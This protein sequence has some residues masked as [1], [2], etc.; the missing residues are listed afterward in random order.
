VSLQLLAAM[1]REKL[2][3][4]GG[5]ALRDVL[6]LAQKTL[7][8]ARRAVW[9]MRPPALEG[10]D[11]A[12]SLKGAIEETLAGTA[13]ELDY[14][15]R[16][17]PRRLEP[18]VETVVYR[19]AQAALANVVQHAAASQPRVVL[20]FR[21]RSVRLAVVDDGRGFPVDADLRTYSGRWGLLGMRER[22]SQV[23]GSVSIRSSP[24]KG[25]KVVLRV[26]TRVSLAV[27]NQ[28]IAC[29]SADRSV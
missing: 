28:G 20:S 8:D 3:P 9:D 14:V 27:P 21:R 26:P 1:G 2:T 15:V 25:T 29:E 17:E 23:G 16:G 24:G 7:A 18:D 10:A 11:F 19:V 6:V 12:T 4:E 22:A 5:A 13:L